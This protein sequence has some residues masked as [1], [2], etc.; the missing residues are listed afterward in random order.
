MIDK[1]EFYQKKYLEVSAERVTVFRS[2]K[3]WRS[4][5]PMESV[6]LEFVAGPPKVLKKVAK[7]GKEKHKFSLE[8]F[9][10]A[11]KRDQFARSDYSQEEIET[12]K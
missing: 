12:F 4:R 8:V 3:D 9:S 11:V 10:K 6:S 5:R 2:K 1:E 7:N